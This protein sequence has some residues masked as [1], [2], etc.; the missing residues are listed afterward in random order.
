MSVR[1]T[2]TK[3]VLVNLLRQA[4]TSGQ[5]PPRQRLT[6]L[7]LANALGISRTP[8]R[9][10]LQ[11]L[12]HAGLIHRHPSGR[13]FEVRGYSIEEAFDLV[14][15]RSLLEQGAARELA[16]RGDPDDLARLRDV[17]DW[18]W[19]MLER[20][21]YRTLRSEGKN[22]HVV[23]IECVGS[24]ELLALFYRVLDK[25][26]MIVITNEPDRQRVLKSYED[27]VAIYDAIAARD[28]D[29][30]AA[31]VKAHCDM[32]AE[33]LRRNPDRFQHD[34]GPLDRVLGQFREQLSA[35]ED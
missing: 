13:G 1:P 27:H 35:A 3:E 33:M 19:E 16:R 12:S 15:A 30:A 28:P 18:E 22:F 4:I 5:L 14:F 24:R 25:I 34:E 8:V 26:R 32:A 10:A 7:A 11:S 2:R 29:K 6:E 9:E 21:T 31:L 17:L 23:L 20:R